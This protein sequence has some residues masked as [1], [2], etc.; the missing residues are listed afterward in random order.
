MAA[1]ERYARQ[2]A[3]HYNGPILYG[4][5]PMSTRDRKRD[6]REAPPRREVGFGPNQFDDEREH[7]F[8]DGTFAQY[9]QGLEFEIA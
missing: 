4:A 3:E 6:S 9:S 2:L 5:P 1:D 7:S 8:I